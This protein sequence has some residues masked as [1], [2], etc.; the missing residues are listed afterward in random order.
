MIAS[1]ETHACVDVDAWASGGAGVKMVVFTV[2]E[3]KQSVN[4]AAAR[5]A[6]TR[7]YDDSL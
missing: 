5:S 7:H 3:Q 1:T 2:C 6:V 4:P